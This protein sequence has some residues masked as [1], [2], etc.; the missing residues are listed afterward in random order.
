MNFLE[1]WIFARLAAG[2]VATWL[3]VYAAFVGARVLRHRRLATATEGQLLLE[4][5][6]ELAATAARIGGGVQLVAL[7]LS[8]LAADRLSQGLKGAMCGYGVVHANAWGPWALGLSV[9]AALAAAIFA[10][11]LRFESELST[12][13]FRAIALTSL[14]LAVLASADLVATGWWLGSL[15][16]SVVASC[17]STSLD[18]AGAGALARGA[19]GGGRLPLA[20]AAFLVVSLTV[21]LA[22]AVRTKAGPLTRAPIRV[23]AGL[24]LLALPLGLA[25]VVLEV[26]PH[27]YEA[28]HHLCVYCLL[29][30]DALALGYPLVGALLLGT[31]YAVAAGLASLVAPRSTEAD[32]VL[33][34][35]AR[36]S[37][38]RSSVFFTVFLAL[39]LAPVVRFTVLSGGKSLFP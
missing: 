9:V 11:L 5:Q 18:D 37:L 33:E 29:R 23:V 34:P 25:A 27:V 1:P 20:V 10:G 31:A 8:A 3:F 17:C 32:G 22:R 13:L 6:A 28:P 30:L 39:A 15:D 38:G 2:L 14:P 12:P 16:F 19:S 35:F 24:G 4:R 7:L 36:A 21:I 26:S